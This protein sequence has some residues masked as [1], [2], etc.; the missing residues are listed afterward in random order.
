MAGKDTNNATCRVCGGES[1]PLFTAQVLNKYAVV[2]SRCQQCGFIQTEQP[3]WLDEAYRS[4]MTQLDVG[5]LKRNRELSAVVQTVTG[6]W[7]KRKAPYLDYGGGYGLLVRW[8]RDKGYSFYR[9]DPHAENLF[10]EGFDLGD[11]PTGQQFG[12]VTAFE[13]MEHLPE[14]AKQL[15][16][17]LKHS[18]NVLFSTTLIPKGLQPTGADDWHYFAPETGQHVAFYSLAAL[19]ELAQAHGLRLYS[20]G[21]RIHLLTERRVPRWLFYLVSHWP[22]ARLLLALGV[23]KRPSLLWQ[24]YEARKAALNLT[25]AK[26][27]REA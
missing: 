19:R 27:G 8:L 16:E 14:P 20:N 6:L 15:P 22:V 1:R 3:Y 12:L 5:L 4:A 21:K 7:F 24:D 23:A 18:R 26:A 2:Y 17:M 13:V 10:A 25:T 11:L 9:Y